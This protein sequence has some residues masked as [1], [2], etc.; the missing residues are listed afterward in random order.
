MFNF[1]GERFIPGVS[2]NIELEHLH[3]YLAVRDIVRGKVVADIACGEGYGSSILAKAAKEVYAIDVSSE[4][5]A[6]ARQKYDATNIQFLVADAVDTPLKNG[7][8]D[9]VISFETIEH[10]ARHEE[11]MLEIVRVLDSNGCLV[12]SSPDKY[13]CSEKTNNHNAYHVK[14]LY[15]SDLL[16]LLR[17][18]FSYVKIY[19]QRVHIASLIDAESGGGRSDVFSAHLDSDL[20]SRFE[21]LVPHPMFWICIASNSEEMKD[22]GL[23][24]SALVDPTD[25]ERLRVLA[26]RSLEQEKFINHQARDIRELQDVVRDLQERNA[27][28]NA[29][30]IAYIEHLE[31]DIASLNEGVAAKFAK[32][33]RLRK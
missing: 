15:K 27:A 19:G 30:R 18:H 1:T 26:E 20:E 24:T 7:S 28:E 6:A 14:E 33:L 31:R 5:V 10:H 4:V 21:G 2:G 29:E 9:V 11:M 12:I 16:D 32:L 22:V 8:V 13:E 17:K 25:V 23:A 3:R